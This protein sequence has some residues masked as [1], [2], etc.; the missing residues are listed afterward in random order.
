MSSRGVPI[1]STRLTV[2]CDLARRGGVH[3][4]IGCDHGLAGLRLAQDEGV[5]EVHFVDPSLPVIN[6]LKQTIGSDIPRAL[7]FNIH[8]KKG[9]ELTILPHAQHSFLIAGMGGLQVIK[10]LNHLRPQV[11]ASAQF[12]IS[13]H[14]DILAVR[15][16]LR[17]SSWGLITEV[18]IFEDQ[19]FYEAL[20]LSP[21]GPRP[22]SLY[23]D[24]IWQGP[25]GEAYRQHCLAK[26]SL[27]R[28]L[29][30]RAFLDFLAK[31][32]KDLP[33]LP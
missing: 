15:A 10:I 32:A 28:D 3:W 11:N 16:Y 9:E 26:R 5:E 27:H 13:P 24:K 23:G 7:P 4:D 18:V 29:P 2:L 30:T 17:E 12:V 1:L 19:Q 8:H 33:D 14:R 25:H 6:Q 31:P 20:K 22:V 21:S